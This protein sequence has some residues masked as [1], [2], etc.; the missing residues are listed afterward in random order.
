[1]TRTILVCVTALWLGICAAVTC[2]EEPKPQS[3]YLIGNSL[4]WDTLPGSLDGEVAWHVDCGVNLP[5]I[6]ANPDKPCVDTSK[7]WPAALKEKQYDVVSVQ[8]HYAATIEQDVETISKWMEMQPQAVF[9]IHSGWAFS[10]HQATEFS[11]SEYTGPLSHSPAYYR[12]LVARLK[13]LHP[14]RVIRQTRAINLLEQVAQDSAAKRGPFQA[15]ADLYRDD[16]HMKPESGKYLM[17]NAMRHALGQPRSS[18]GFEPMD[19][20]VKKYLDGLLDLLT[21]ADADQEL[22]EQILSPAENVD[23]PAL[24][25]KVKSEELKS[26]LTALLPRI[27]EAVALRRR[28]LPLQAD[29]KE[30]GGKLYFASRAPQWL[31]L[32]ADDRTTELFETP[33]AID[34]YN[35]NNPLKGRGGKNEAVTEA[36]LKRIAEFSTIQKLD[37]SNCSLEDAWLQHVGTIA[38]LQELNLMLTPITDAGL[39]HL[40][41]LTELRVLGLASSQCN[42]TGFAHLTA[43]KKLENVNF[44]YTPLNDAGLCAISKVGVSDRLWF[45]HTHFTDKGAE[46]LANLTVLRRCGIGSQEAGSSGEAVAALA[47]VPLEELYLLDK[48]ATPAAIVYA[49]KIDSLRLLEIAYAPEVEDAS[50]KLIAG[51]PHLEEF[52]IGSAKITDEGL[53]VLA[54]SKSLKKVVLSQLKNVSEAGIMK[55]QTAKPELKIE[56]N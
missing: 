26:K 14:D 27:D 30:I 37:I 43:L 38:G 34:L 1:M 8:P 3:F 12:E 15:I 32:A 11:K 9:V 13:H 39:A 46:C 25:A 2:A 47:K 52:R 29:L 33:V 4:T 18:K 42:G 23:R 50:L 24:I 45:A 48:Q 56:V 31:Y 49:A 36:W 16:I 51:M 5:H 7:L 28:T 10:K 17:H 35:G 21:L 19:T 22:L 40:H 53:Q 41:G 55:L 54:E 20:E 44:H 6:Y